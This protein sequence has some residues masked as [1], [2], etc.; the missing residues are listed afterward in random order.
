[1]AAGTVIELNAGINFHRRTAVPLDGEE[2]AV[3]PRRNG[4]LNSHRVGRGAV[5]G[6]AK[7]IDTC[8]EY[9]VFNR[10][11]GGNQCKALSNDSNKEQTKRQTSTVMMKT[12]GNILHIF[13]CFFQDSMNL[14]HE[15]G[16]GI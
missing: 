4:L 12:I 6:R 10:G 8:A 5:S 13:N 9:Y 2:N 1:M 3:T 16:V 7:E 11:E 14:N 15:I